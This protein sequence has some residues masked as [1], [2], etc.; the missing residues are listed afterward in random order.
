MDWFSSAFLSGSG[1]TSATEYSGFFWGVLILTL[2]L[3]GGYTAVAHLKSF[4]GKQ[5]DSDTVG[6]K[7]IPLI[8]VVVFS[9]AII[10]TLGGI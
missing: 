8:L 1:G 10:T 7:L 9:L 4:R 2:L 3:W 5:L 6:K